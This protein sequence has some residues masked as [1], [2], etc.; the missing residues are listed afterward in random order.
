MCSSCMVPASARSPEQTTSASF[1]CQMKRS[2]ARLT[3]RSRIL[4]RNDIREITCGAP[5]CSESEENGLLG[6]LLGG[7]ALQRCDSVRVAHHRAVRY[8]QHVGGNF[9]VAK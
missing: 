9:N 3:S 4:S 5:L 8:Q 6:R 1:S 2:S 7:A